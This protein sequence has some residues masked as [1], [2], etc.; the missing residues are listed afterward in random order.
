MSL[1]GGSDNIGDF[2][3]K[4]HRELARYAKGKPSGAERDP[5]RDT[6]RPFRCYVNPENPSESV[7]Y[8]TLRWQMQAFYAIFALSFPAVGAGLVIGSLVGIRTAK[9]ES[10]LA[11]RHPGEP[12]KCKLNWAEST[13]PESTAAGTRALIPYTIWAAL[14]IAPLIVTTAMTG[15]FQTDRMAWLLMIFVASG[16]SRP[17]TRSNACATG[18]RSGRRVSNSRNHPHGRAACCAAIFC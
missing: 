3:Q 1:Q 14:I 16:V 12:W 18:S 11:A 4:A 9:R 2:Q 13:I 6:R 5:Q 17:G 7:I 10:A 15:A 8:R